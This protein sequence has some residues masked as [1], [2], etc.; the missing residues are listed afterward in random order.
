MTTVL[1][2]KTFRQAMG[3]FATGVTVMATEADGE[4]HAMTANAFSSLS[5]DPP[6][7]L[8]CLKRGAKMEHLINQGSYFSVSFLS[9]QQELLSTYF[10]G[11]SKDGTVPDFQFQP[12][13]NTVRLQGSICS[14][15]C[16][17]HE[18]VEGGDHV[19]VFG[20]VMD[21]DMD[22]QGTPLLFYKGKY[23]TLARAEQV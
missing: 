12:W 22:S 7:I 17:V 10:A 20:R 3:M 15:A 9:E 5:L 13:S 19:V 18:I 16:Q 1:D 14:V 6:L 8:I 11:G 21:I 2:T 4:L 23:Q